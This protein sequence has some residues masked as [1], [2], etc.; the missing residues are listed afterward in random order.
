MHRHSCWAFRYLNGGC[1]Y[2]DTFPSQCGYYDDEDFQANAMCCNCGGGKN[3]ESSYCQKENRNCLQGTEYCCDCQCTFCGPR[4]YCLNHSPFENHCGLIIC[5]AL[6]NNCENYFEECGNADSS[7]IQLKSLL[8]EVDA[9]KEDVTKL[10]ASVQEVEKKQER[11]AREAATGPVGT[12]G[13]KGDR[14]ETGVGLPV[15][16]GRNGHNG[17]HGEAVPRHTIISALLLLHSG[18]RGGNGIK[19]AKEEERNQA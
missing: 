2:Y 8:K 4:E 1:E 9:L 3:T 5:S 6:G 13:V 17:Q 16:S 11:L 14:G 19:G 12:P 15:V 7:N 18:S 10:T